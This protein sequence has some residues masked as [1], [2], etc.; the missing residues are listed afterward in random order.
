MMMMM[1]KENKHIPIIKKIAVN[2]MMM[3]KFIHELLFPPNQLIFSRLVMFLAKVNIFTIIDKD[4]GKVPPRIQASFIRCPKR[5]R[6]QPLPNP[7]PP[8][9]ITRLKLRLL[10]Q[11]PP[12][13]LDPSHESVSSSRLAMERR[14]LSYRK[15]NHNPSRTVDC[16]LCPLKHHPPLCKISTIPSS[17]API[18]TPH[19]Q[20]HL[21]PLLLGSQYLQII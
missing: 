20:P 17:H 19:T 1:M 7:R 4:K 8:Q 21:V 13:G 9:R 15:M 10:R 2:I 12:R 11:D 5:L 3:I 18:P 6:Y 14:S 16:R